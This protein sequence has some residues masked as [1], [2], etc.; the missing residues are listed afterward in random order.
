M[1]K[2]TMPHPSINKTEGVQGE[3]P[4]LEFAENLFVLTYDGGFGISKFELQGHA[5]KL[6]KPTDLGNG[7]K[8]VRSDVI[9]PSAQTRSVKVEIQNQGRKPAWK[10]STYVMTEI[11]EFET[12]QPHGEWLNPRA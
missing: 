9:L 2:M 7:L 10:I 6:G 12:V 4:V 5:V 8:V 3:D 11:P 1:N